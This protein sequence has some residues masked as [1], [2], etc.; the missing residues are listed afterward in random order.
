MVG[1]LNRRTVVRLKKSLRYKTARAL[2]RVGRV[3]PGPV[4][5]EIRRLLGVRNAVVAHFF[6]VQMRRPELL[7][8]Y[9]RLVASNVASVLL[10]IMGRFYADLGV[11]AHSVPLVKTLES[12]R[13][14]LPSDNLATRQ[15]QAEPVLIKF[16]RA[17]ALAEAGRLGEALPLFEAVFQNNMARKFVSYDPYVREAI[18]RSGE[19]LGRYHEKR[20][21]GDASIAIYREILSIDQDGPIARRLTLL[22][23]R[24]GD[25]REAAEVAEIASQ[26]TPNLFPRIP[27]NNPYIAALETEFF[28]KSAA[29]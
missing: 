4:R 10:K 28:G 21:D 11:D 1:R 26:S 9:H 16:E 14:E 24:R 6:R 7:D 23:S 15:R 25:L 20:G 5:R 12:Y 27:E 18:V 13:R 22:L 29:P 3:V 19:F 2:G 8:E 17:F